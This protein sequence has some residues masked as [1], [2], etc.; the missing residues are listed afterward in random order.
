[1]RVV[2]GWIMPADAFCAAAGL[3]TESFLAENE[4][5]IAAMAW[6]R[7]LADVQEVIIPR[8]GDGYYE[9]EGASVLLIQE[10]LMETDESG[11]VT[12]AELIPPSLCQIDI[13]GEMQE[14]LYSAGFS[15]VYGPMLVMTS[16]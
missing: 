2:S 9:Y 1:M 5:C 3:Q 15:P 13:N 6:L 11:P 12:M 16:S 10:T 14:R 4:Q 8:D 7:G